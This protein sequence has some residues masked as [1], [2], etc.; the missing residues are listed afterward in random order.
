MK[1]FCSSFK[2]VG[3]QATRRD[4]TMLQPVFYPFLVPVH[5]LSHNDFSLTLLSALEPRQITRWDVHKLTRSA[6]DIGVR[7]FGGCCGF[8]AYHIRAISEEV[9][10][11]E[12][13]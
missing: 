8:K 1:G 3:N 11:K 13:A 10:K 7:Y 9:S 5:Y 4:T 12:R 6:Y 2:S